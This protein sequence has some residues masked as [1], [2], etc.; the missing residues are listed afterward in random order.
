MAS[1]PASFVT[2]FAQRRC[3]ADHFKANKVGNSEQKYSGFRLLRK[4]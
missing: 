3:D 4:R 2:R 1:M